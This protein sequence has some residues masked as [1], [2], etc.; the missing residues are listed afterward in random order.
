[1]CPENLQFALERLHEKY[2]LPILITENGVAD[3]SDEDRKWWITHTIIAMQKAMA[4]GVKLQGYLHWSLLDNFEWAYGK[5]PS[6]GLV[7]VDYKT[8]KRT[9]RPSAIWLATIIKKLQQEK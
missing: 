6:F 1:M 3:E 4:N 9:V 7:E 8:M 5:W 2:G